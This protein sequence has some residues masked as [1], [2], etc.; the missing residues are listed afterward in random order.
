MYKFNKIKKNRGFTII[1]LI[2]STAIFTI[3]LTLISSAMILIFNGYKKTNSLSK[4]L[5]EFDFTFGLLMKEIRFSSDY[6]V[7]S[8]GCSNTSFEYESAFRGGRN[9]VLYLDNGSLVRKIGSDSPVKLTSPNIEITKL[10]FYDA[11]P[12]FLRHPMLTISLTAKIENKNGVFSEF[13]IQDS[14]SSRAF[15]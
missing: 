4:V 11:D 8:S 1:E 6:V 10:C 13:T 7:N 3:A 12:L 15:Y 2:I 14:V 5:N 9:V